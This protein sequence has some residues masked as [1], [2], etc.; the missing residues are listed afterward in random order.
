MIEPFFTAIAVSFAT[1][2]FMEA[3]VKTKLENLIKWWKLSNRTA[4]DRGSG[5][6]IPRGCSALPH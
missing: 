6:L 2:V 5:D 3:K 1:F 4:G